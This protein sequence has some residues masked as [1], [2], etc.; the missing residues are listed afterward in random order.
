MFFVCSF[1]FFILRRM[2]TPVDK[3]LGQT[4]G[5]ESPPCHVTFDPLSSG[6]DM[7]VD[8]VPDSII[9]KSK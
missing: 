8:G 3:C 5:D 1:V 9:T 6:T 7:K 4:P 2:T